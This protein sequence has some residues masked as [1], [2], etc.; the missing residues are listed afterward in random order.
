VEEVMKVI[1]RA[2]IINV[3]KQGDVKEV[4]AGFARNYLLPKQL[5]M[6]AIPSNIKLWEKEK[7]RFEKQRV[8]IV[9]TARE[10]ADKIE[11]TPI[12]VQAK[13][14]GSG[15]LFGSVTNVAIARALEENGFLVDKHDIVLPEPIKEAGVYTIDI[16]LQPE[17]TAR[18]RISVVGEGAKEHEQHS[19]AT[20]L[21]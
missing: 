7:K 20:E 6:E 13:A 14:G 21:K 4:S 5:V 19:P 2:D 10:L 16:R 11:K 18:A 17:V 1:L 3:G 9:T 15:K 12:T 8:E